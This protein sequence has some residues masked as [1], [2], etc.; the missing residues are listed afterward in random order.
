VCVAPGMTAGLL[1]LVN[2]LLPAGGG[3]NSERTIG[4]DV[5]S[6]T[7]PS[8]LTYLGRR[9]GRKWNQYSEERRA[10]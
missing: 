5:P 8:P 6:I 2:R 9:A 7:E 10:S 1:G 4:K 3:N